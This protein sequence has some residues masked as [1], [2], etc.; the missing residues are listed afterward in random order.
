M[1][2]SLESFS[3]DFSKEFDIYSLGIVF[4]EILT[5]KES[6]FDFKQ[7]KSNEIFQK[8]INEYLRSIITN[9]NS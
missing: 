6:Y 3:G 8:I 9:K 1:W 7:P 4:W 2:K 5:T